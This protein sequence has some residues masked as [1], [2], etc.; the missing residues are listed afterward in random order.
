[1]AKFNFYT[2]AERSKLMGKIRS[3]HTKPELAL[4]KELWKLGFRYRIHVKK[5]KGSPDI[6]F[7]NY[8]VAVFVD[9]EF[10]HGYQWAE[11]K[12]KLN[13]NAEY[14][15][16]KIERN[17]DRDK[18]S[19]EYLFSKGYTVLRFW[20]HQ[21]KKDIGGCTL[22]IVMAISKNKTLEITGDI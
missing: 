4:R 5:L 16:Q 8:K 17:I 18:E 3:K 15:I 19:N 22:A 9:G 10:W 2:S 20:E 13:A 11:K 14:W 1:M 7:Q 6:V 12:Q 21:I